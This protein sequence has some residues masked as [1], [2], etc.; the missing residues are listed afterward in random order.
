MASR[1][2]IPT[3]GTTG[4]SQES[5]LDTIRIGE[6]KRDNVARHID[7]GEY[8]MRQIR[9]PLAATPK[10]CI[11][12]QTKDGRTISFLPFSLLLFRNS[13]G[14]FHWESEKQNGREREIHGFALPTKNRAVTYWTPVHLLALQTRPM[15]IDGP[16]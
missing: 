4:C 5:T 8:L 6:E 10:I 13:V 9:W 15:N 2:S 3:H 12:E 11:S 16:A 7:T 1:G 14:W